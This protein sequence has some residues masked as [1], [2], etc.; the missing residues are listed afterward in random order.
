MK[1]YYFSKFLSKVILV[2]MLKNAGERRKFCILT[3][4]YGKI[5]KLEH[6]FPFFFADFSGGGGRTSPPPPLNP[7]LLRTHLQNHVGELK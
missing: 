1:K 6:F 5:A 7:L 4:K 2:I 3:I